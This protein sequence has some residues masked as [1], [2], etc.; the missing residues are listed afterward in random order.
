MTPRMEMG[1][2][3]RRKKEEEE[4]E[5]EEEELEQVQEVVEGKK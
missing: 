2:I 3:R 1:R 4:K 5:E